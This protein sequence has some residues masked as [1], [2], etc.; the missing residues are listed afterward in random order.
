MSSATPTTTPTEQ[1]ME[2][3]REYLLQNYSRYPLALERGE[4]C[5][6]YD[7]EGKRYLDFIAGIGVN[8]LGHNHPR[9]VNVIREQSALLIHCSNLYYHRYQGLLAKKLAEVSGLQRSFFANSGTEAMEGALKMARAHGRKI[10]PGK[11]EILSLENSFHGRSLGALSVTGQSKYR[12]DFE[13]LLP[14]VKFVPPNEVRALEAAFNERTAGMVIEWIQGEGGIFPISGEYA[15]R[16]RELADRY[17]ALLVFDEIQCGVGRPGTWV[18]Y[19]LAT[20]VVLPDVM[21]AAKP[22][23]CGLP[24][25]VIVANERAA[26]A[27]GPG[28]HGSTFGGSALAC[29]V[30]LEF[31]DILD[32]LLPQI[33]RVGDYFRER[34]GDLG[35]KYGFIREV[36]GHGLMIGLELEVSGKQM[37]LDAQARGLLI[38][39]THDT[40]LRFLPPYIVTESEVDQAVRILDSIFAAQPP[41]GE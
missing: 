14:G 4:G 33:R 10:D 28:M 19:Q 27:I 5:F 12:Q 17:D 25:G 20:P 6:V 36:R 7:V 37:V 39:C 15:R 13:P 8:A 34:L 29:R 40:V 26:A 30:A 31:F 21:V 2:L 18:G 38:N 23:A 1:I 32:E 16:A 24:L 22:L 3:E 41:A 11:F 9:I 35:R